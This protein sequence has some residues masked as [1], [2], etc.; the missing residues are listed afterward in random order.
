MVM[1]AAFITHFQYQSWIASCREERG[2]GRIYEATPAQCRPEISVA[3]SEWTCEHFVVD[4]IISGQL[5]AL[6]H[7]LLVMKGAGEDQL[8]LEAG[9]ASLMSSWR[10]HCPSS[11]SQHLMYVHFHLLKGR[12][13]QLVTLCHP[14]LTYIHF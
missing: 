11:A 3:S 13:F 2:S 4:Q 1:L 8:L 9:I 6:R 10:W 14:G 12:D 7:T 5:S